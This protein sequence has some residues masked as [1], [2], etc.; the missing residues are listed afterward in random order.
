MEMNCVDFIAIFFLNYEGGQI[1]LVF[2]LIVLACAQ[3]N[4]ILNVCQPFVFAQNRT[5]SIK[6]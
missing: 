1:I 2:F 5:V 4:S 6:I 3:L